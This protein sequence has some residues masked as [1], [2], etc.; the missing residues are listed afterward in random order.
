VTTSHEL[1][2]ELAIGHALN[3]LEPE[4]EV[5]FLAHLP[6]C[7]ACERAIDEHQQTM[8][9]LAYAVASE[10][11][12]ASLLEG[13]RAGVA[14]SGRAGSFPA[15]ISLDARRQQRTVRMRTALVGV[16]A[17]FVLLAALLIT[18]L[19]L[20]SKNNDLQHRQEAFKA[21]VSTLLTP[22]A[23]D[24]PLAGADGQ[25]AAVI[26][27]SNVKLV[28]AGVT[29]NDTKSETYVLWE[30][31]SRGL[32]H[33]AG[34]FD[35]TKSDVNVVQT[36]LK[37]SHPSDVDRLMVTKE[38]GRTAPAHNSQILFTGQV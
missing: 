19:S 18:S 10:E 14:A 9:H 15:P 8:G 17:S 21:S 35:V 32:P 24:V 3:A 13:I 34:V 38:P 5:I 11:P 30:Q 25:A 37:L 16:A 6:G 31:D 29:P 33:A 36:G 28:L 22:G 4:D 7:A 23:R 1:Y 27:G 2:E 12:P 26:S 20:Q